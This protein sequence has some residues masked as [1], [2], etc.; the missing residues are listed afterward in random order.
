MT[1]FPFITTRYPEAAMIACIST[2][3]KHDYGVEWIR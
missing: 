2:S 1:L 3:I